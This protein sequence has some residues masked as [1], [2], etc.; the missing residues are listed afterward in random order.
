MSVNKGYPVSSNLSA[1][2]NN[3]VTHFDDDRSFGNLEGLNEGV[4]IFQIKIDIQ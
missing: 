3:V 1:F 4:L 2:F